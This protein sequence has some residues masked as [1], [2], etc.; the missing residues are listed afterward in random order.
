MT[1]PA[2]PSH[3]LS[4]YPSQRVFLSGEA[5][6]RFERRG[7]GAPPRGADTVRDPFIQTATRLYKDLSTADSQHRFQPNRVLGPGSLRQ[8]RGS[9]EALFCYTASLFLH[10]FALQIID[11]SGEGEVL[12]H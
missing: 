2:Y 7:S 10:S 3:A 6:E 4:R 11:K 8:A 9:V 12:A 5:L 1:T